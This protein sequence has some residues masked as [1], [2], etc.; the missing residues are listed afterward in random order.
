[1]TVVKNQAPISRSFGPEHDRSLLTE[2]HVGGHTVY[3]ELTQIIFSEVV[4]AWY[5]SRAIV[6]KSG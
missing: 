5:Y 1:M 6:Y 3:K 2:L 4:I